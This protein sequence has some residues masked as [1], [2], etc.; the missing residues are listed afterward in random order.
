M[1]SSH[2]DMIKVP[3]IIRYPDIV[4]SNKISDSMQSLVDLAPTFLDFCN[5]KI[6]NKMTGVS[7]KNVWSDKVLNVRNHIICEDHHEPTTIHLKTFVNKR[8]KLTVYYNHTYGELFDL[9]NDPNELNNLWDN[10]N[11][12]DLKMEL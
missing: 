5:I 7:Q 2:E 9:Q 12:K 8:Y 1:G 3:F 10:E 11:F 6:P 4:P